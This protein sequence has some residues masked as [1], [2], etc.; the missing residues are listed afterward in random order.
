MT[1][2]FLI[3]GLFIVLGLMLSIFTQFSIKII[4]IALGAAAVVKG[5]YDLAKVKKLSKDAGFNRMVLIRS[6]A[7]ILVGLLAF[8]LPLAFFRTAETVVKV[9]LYLLAIF[10]MI[11]GVLQLFLVAKL[12]QEEVPAPTKPMKIEAVSYFLVAIFLFL[13]ASINIT[14]IIRIVG[15]LLVIVGVIYC[16]YLWHNRTLVINPDSVEDEPEDA[17]Q[18]NSVQFE[19]IE[20]NSSDEEE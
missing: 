5:L 18:D 8:F 2:D 15:I 14:G 16:I 13:V 12:N 19:Q 10:L 1:V 17:E 11:S 6:L 4:V 20:D 3:S 9:M 7:G